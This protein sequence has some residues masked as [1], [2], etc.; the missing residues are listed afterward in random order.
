MMDFSEM[1]SVMDTLRLANK[2]SALKQQQRAILIPGWID[3]LDTVK[4]NTK[5]EHVSSLTEFQKELKSLLD[6][7]SLPT[8]WSLRIMQTYSN[9]PF[10]EGFLRRV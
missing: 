1:P 2:L 3:W 6:Q 5:P 8:G 10:Y 7:E 9:Y 4:Q